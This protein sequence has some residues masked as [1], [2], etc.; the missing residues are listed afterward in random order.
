MIGEKQKKIL[1][2]SFSKYDTLICDGAIRTGKT[3]LMMVAFVDWAMREFDGRRFGICGKTVGSATE[4]I[5]MPY[6]Q[7]TY[8]I[9]K[10]YNVRWRSSQKILEVRKG[11]RCNVFEVFGGKDESSFALIQ[12]RTLAGVL[13]DEVVLMPESFVNQALARC[14]VEGSRAWFN[15][16]PS[17]PHHWFYKKWIQHR[18]EQNAL[19]LHFELEDN[20]SLSEKIKERYNRQYSGVFYD[21]YIKGLWVAAEGLIYKGYADALEDVYDG[22]I[23]DWCVSC[24]YG[25]QNAF[26]A[27]KW[28]K[29]SE[30]VWHCLAEYYYSGRDE[31]YAKTDDDYLRD[32]FEFCRD[33]QDERVEFIVDPSA[34][35]FITALKRSDRFRVR[36]A[37][38]E[39][40]KGIND[41]AVAMQRGLVK[42]GNKCENTIDELAGYC[43]DGKDD[44][45]VKENDHG[46]DALRYFVE[47]KKIITIKNEDYVS[48]FER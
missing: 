38:N 19:Y 48:P 14:S 33:I 45:P 18:E 12:G 39:V 11:S 29:D 9:C 5:I 47:T 42:I 8:P 40:V 25:T 3:S 37:K 34:A 6:L 46:C 31:G 41:T 36:K 23:T 4:N 28:G 7:M 2:F 1:A 26:A 24:D 16:N 27:L 35:S 43:W 44:K 30:G 32:M 10:G 13:L 20:P 15:C 21:R 22:N 17:S